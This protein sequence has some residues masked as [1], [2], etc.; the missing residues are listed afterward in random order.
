M[1]KDERALGIICMFLEADNF[2]H[3]DF[4]KSIFPHN[5]ILQKTEAYMGDARK[6]AV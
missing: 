2:F 5:D 3:N 1:Q 6:E 4:Y